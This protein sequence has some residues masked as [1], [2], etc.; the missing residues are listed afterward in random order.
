MRVSDISLHSNFDLDKELL[1]DQSPPDLSRDNSDAHET[2]RHPIATK[3]PSKHKS[4]VLPKLNINIGG[5][6]RATVP[7]QPTP[8]K[9]S[10]DMS[11]LKLKDGQLPLR[12][13]PT[14]ELRHTET[15]AV[16]PSAGLLDLDA[17]LQNYS[18]EEKEKKVEVEERKQLT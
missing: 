5:G 9:L 10:L 18:D 13:A 4:A 12:V 14:D 7:V 2:A 1:D 17:I 6:S 15:H 16:K 3:N 11:R 8:L